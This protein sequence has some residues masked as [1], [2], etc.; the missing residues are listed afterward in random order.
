MTK[1]VHDGRKES[2]GPFEE[3]GKEEDDGEEPHHAR[4]PRPSRMGKCQV[5]S[6]GKLAKYR[7]PACEVASCSL[8]CSR[9]H[10]TMGGGCSGKRDRTA[11]KDIR[12]FTDADV[13]S[14]YRFLEEALLERERAKRWRPQYGIGSGAAARSDRPPATA[15]VI[16]LLTQ[17]AKARGVE[18]FC[19]PDGMARRVANT[20]FFDRRRDVL[21]W[22]IEWLFY[23]SDNGN[24]GVGN[25]S[26]G[27]NGD[28]DREG[29]CICGSPGAGAS[30]RRGAMLARPVAKAEDAK[31]DET[32]TIFTALRKHLKQGPGQAARLHELR[33][34][35]S[36]MKNATSSA[37]SSS[38]PATDLA[39]F[40]EKE[41]CPANARRFFKLKL[42]DTLKAS[43]EGKRLLEFP[44]LHVAVLPEDAAKFPEPEE[45]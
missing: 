25:N 33:R 15:K 9:A 14:D 41:G 22:R 42:D 21:Q 36:A 40:L 23:G 6:E 31:V 1:G 2:E 45:L 38:N 8:E 20:T 29:N 39:V 16:A 32:T 17:Q 12:D 26:E 10:K 30:G 27:I 43:L 18:L 4:Q 5:C 44:T 34:Y 28:S 7:C 13:V 11:F 19:M 24:R 35:T 37:G 3:E